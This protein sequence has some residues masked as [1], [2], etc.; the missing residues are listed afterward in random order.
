MKKIKLFSLALV[1]LAC[2]VVLTGCDLFGSKLK[3]QETLTITAVANKKIG[4][5]FQLATTGGS[6]TGAVTYEKVSGTATISSAGAVSEITVAGDIVVKAKKA[7]D[8]DYKE[9]ISNELIITIGKTT[10]VIETEPVAS[11]I[12]YGAA[13]ST[14][15]LSDGVANVEGTFTWQNGATIPTVTNTGY[16]V[17]F[18][19]TDTEYYETVTIQNIAI[20]VAKATPTAIVFPVATAA[21]YTPTL[22]LAQI[23]LTSG[24][25]NGTFTWT[26]ATTPIS[27]ANSGTGYSVTFTPND[28]DNYI[29]TAQNV[30]ITVNK[31]NQ[32]A[33]TVNAEP[34][35]T[36]GDEPFQLGTTG[37]TVGAITYELVSGSAEV[38]S[39]GEVT[40]TGAGNIIVNATRAG[41]AN[42]NSITS[43]NC[44]IS[45]AKASQATL[46][47]T[48]PGTIYEFS[49]TAS[50]VQLAT[51]GGSGTGE[52]TYVKASGQGTISSSGL[53]SFNNNSIYSLIT[54]TA[55][56][57]GDNNYL[58]TSTQITIRTAPMR[59]KLVDD[60]YTIDASVSG[61]VIS[62]VLTIPSSYNDIAITAIGANAFYGR[63]AITDIIIPSSIKNI[64]YQAFTMCS[65]LETVTFASDSQL[66]TFGSALF[67]GCGKLTGIEIPSNVKTIEY[68]AFGDCVGLET[69]VFASGSLLESIGDGVFGG[70]TS[71]ESIEIPASVISI[72]SGAFSICTKL[73]SVVFAGGSLLERIGDGA[74]TKCTSLA[75]ISI[76]ASVTSIGSNAFIL[77]KIYTDTPVNQYVYADKWIVGFSSGTPPTTLTIAT[78]TVGIADGAF[79]SDSYLQSVI[80]PDTI[81]Y[82]GARAFEDCTGITSLIIPNSVEIILEEA[83]LNWTDSQTITFIGNKSKIANWDT[84]W[85]NECD[86][87][88]IWQLETPQNLRITSQDASGIKLEWDAVAGASGVSVYVNG[89]FK[90]AFPGGTPM[91][92]V[93]FFG[94]GISTPGNYDIS[95]TVNASGYQASL[96]SDP[97]VL[98]Y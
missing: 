9:A 90:I 36:F 13:L 97:V 91:A 20:A 62:G 70:C 41:D 83:F 7:A 49:G 18:T 77:S 82:V 15:T 28:T 56:K 16:T 24:T 69:V 30:T 23:S 73:A 22:T 80:I 63:T 27:V 94:L 59:L 95:I 57:A 53:L 81:K 3:D 46:S 65:N 68:S 8:K 89:S 31:A 51:T 40:I 50:T 75:S 2:G 4:D 43:T 61:T 85:D 35:K 72:G 29:P 17:V 25:G 54:I 10:P 5:T 64:E 21:T 52:V 26:T 14:S 47:I 76:P 66:E 74:F 11:G 34:G 79:S 86:A 6:G 19:P 60:T 78:G 38:T 98:T 87:V 71:L 96:Q 42:Y 92:V 84:N 93:G 1:L 39:G 12:T 32:A 44:T 58:S 33:L 67:Y 88:I 55:S 37:G 45:V 48:D